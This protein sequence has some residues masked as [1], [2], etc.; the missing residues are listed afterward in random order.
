MIPV[1]YRKIPETIAFYAVG[2]ELLITLKDCREY[3]DG[4]T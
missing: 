1:R 3:G 2:S 4:V